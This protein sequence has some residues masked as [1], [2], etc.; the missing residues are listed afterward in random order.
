MRAEAGSG[1]RQPDPDTHDGPRPPGN[2]RGQALGG[3]LLS[4][5]GCPAAKR[6][7]RLGDGQRGRG[8]PELLL[9]GRRPRQPGLQP[10]GRRS[11]PRRRPVG[12]L[13]AL[14]DR[15]GDARWPP[16]DR[17]APR[18]PALLS[19]SRSPGRE[20]LLPAG[21][22]PAAEPRPS[23][24]LRDR[25]LRAAG[26]GAPGRRRASGRPDD[27]RHRR[28]RHH[29]RHARP[30][31]DPGAGWQGPGQGPREARDRICAGK[32]ADRVYAGSSGD[33]LAGEDGKDR[34]FGQAGKTTGSW[35]TARRDVLSGGRGSD[36]INRRPARQLRGS[37]GRQVQELLRSRSARRAAWSHAGALQHPGL[38]R[39]VR[40]VR[41]R[42]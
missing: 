28:A 38:V 21:E 32:G 35:A 3:S 18:R 17:A 11:S 25:Q 24:C 29:P 20:S 31:R 41:R 8:R 6:D 40:G 12:H 37:R 36:V 19:T 4:S 7:D 10:R 5:A 26:A 34:L 9:A 27:H 30:R 1:R 39:L 2:R 13:A 14:Q 15:S 33:R 23:G 22:R 16:A 42:A